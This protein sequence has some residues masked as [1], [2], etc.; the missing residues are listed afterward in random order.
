MN[1]NKKYSLHLFVC[2]RVKDLKF[3]L[4]EALI[5]TNE[6]NEIIVHGTR[7]L[8]IIIKKAELYKDRGKGYDPPSPST[9]FS[10]YPKK[11]LEG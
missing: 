10:L 7:A 8:L 6:A 4:F 2:L 9:V 5:D 1:C 3:Q 11:S